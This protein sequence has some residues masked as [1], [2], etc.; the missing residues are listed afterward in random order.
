MTLHP[1]HP[2]AGFRTPILPSTTAHLLSCKHWN[3]IPCLKFGWAMYDLLPATILRNLKRLKNEEKL[4][5]N[6]EPPN[7]AEA[8][9]VLSPS[10]L[11]PE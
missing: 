9:P 6:S 8:S 4:L 3:Q 5:K 1:K 10:L 11:A 2:Q 7:P